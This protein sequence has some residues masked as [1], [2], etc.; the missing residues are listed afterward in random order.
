MSTVHKSSNTYCTRVVEPAWNQ[1]GTTRC[2]RWPSSFSTAWWWVYWQE[3]E[4]EEG[5][6]DMIGEDADV[7]DGNIFDLF[8]SA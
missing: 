4:G 2:L 5:E 3:T 7:L 6:G 8:S 1:P